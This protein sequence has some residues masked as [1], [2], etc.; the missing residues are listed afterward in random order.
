VLYTTASVAESSVSARQG[1]KTSVS[2]DIRAPTQLH[3]LHTVNSRYNDAFRA[4][5]FDRYNEVIS[6]MT[7]YIN[8]I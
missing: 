8:I 5:P 6:I 4:P 2:G 3:F 7:D 1:T